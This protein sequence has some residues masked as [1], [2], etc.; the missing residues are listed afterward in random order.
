MNPREK[1]FAHP[2][3]RIGGEKTNKE[4]LSKRFKI[5]YT[6]I[7]MKYSEVTSLLYSDP[8]VL[9]AEVE[10]LFSKYPFIVGHQSVIPENGAAEFSYLGKTFLI[11]NGKEGNTL[12][13]NSCPHRLTSFAG[14]GEVV[15]DIHCPYHGFEFDHRGKGLNNHECLQSEILFRKDGFI[16]KGE[17]GI[18][19]TVLDQIKDLRLYGTK[20]FAAKAN[21]KA[22]LENLLDQAHIPFVHQSTLAGLFSSKEISRVENE[23]TFRFEVRNKKGDVEYTKYF[24]F[25][26]MVINVGKRF[27]TVYVLVPQ[28]ESETRIHYYLLMDPL[29]YPFGFLISRLSQRV[30]QEDLRVLEL[31]QKGQGADAIE[32][33]IIEKMDTFSAHFFKRYLTLLNND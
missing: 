26:N 8:A 23:N 27:S 31:F 18:D 5:C 29:F 15:K 3:D 2:S 20:F 1:D 33:K 13:K 14:E 25:P 19:Q 16:F 17:S 32:H 24:L 21:W 22:C 28:S 12:L 6:K 4:K 9:K 30:M 10:K 7:V 11:S